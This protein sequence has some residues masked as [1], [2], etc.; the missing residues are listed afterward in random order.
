[1]EEVKK[2]I[3]RLIEDNEFIYS[4]LSNLRNKSHNEFNKVNIKPV[5]IKDDIRFQFSYEYEK[6]VIHKN[7]LKY[8]AI[9]EVERLLM[10]NFKQMVIFSKTND[11]QILT[12]KKNKFTILKQKPTKKEV[13]LNHNRKKTYLIEEGKCC[14]FLVKLGVMNEKGQVLSKK[15]DKF[16]QINRFL[17]MVQDVVS[18]LD[19]E[20]TINIIDFGCGKSYLTFALY[21]YLVKILNLDVNI[22]GLDLKEDV[23]KYCNEVAD[24]LDYKKLQFIC[25]DIKDYESF[26]EVDMVVTLHACDNATDIALIKAINWNAK[27]ILSVPCCQHELYNKINNI[28]LSP[29]LDHGII[30]ERMAS[31]VTDSIRA[32]VL[33]I[34]GYNVQLLEFIDMEH[35]PKNILIR[36]VKGKQ[37]YNKE[38]I[39]KYIA[40]KKLLGLDY[41]YI[42]EALGESFKKFLKV[43]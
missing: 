9:E 22:V 15:Q 14:D 13:N 18:K 6:K 31:L 35:T 41:L 32:S 27:V 8:E 39:N 1:M 7:L 37:L 26:H 11:Y 30:K 16:K 23:I 19:K 21:Y 29:M 28:D 5:L 34:L 38:D 3:D 17:E 33:N 12:N 43:D 40:F 10:E 24:E 20:K 4:V 42:E 2:L 36:A 25:G